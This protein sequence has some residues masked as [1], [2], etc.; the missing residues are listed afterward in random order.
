MS[1][2]LGD[3][4]A[5]DACL[6]H[7]R[8]LFAENRNDI[9]RR[10]DR[11]F[12]VLILCEW[13]A[14]MVVALIVS[15]RTWAGASSWVHIHVWAALGLGGAIASLPVVLALTRPGRIGTRHVIAAGQMLMGALLIHL[16]GGRIETHF[17][18]FGSLA[19]LAFYR[20]WRV[21]VTASVV[22][23]VD[24]LMRGSFWPRSV[25]GI[26]IFEP[27]RWVEHAGWVVFE[28][29]FL[30][31]FCLESTREMWRAAEREIEL[32]QKRA[33]EALRKARDELEMRV[34]DR[35]AE[36]AQINETLQAEITERKRAEEQLRS[37]DRARRALKSCNQ[38]L[39]RARDE[40]Q[41]L[42][43]LCRVIVH[44]AGYSL[45]W[46]GY[47]EQDEA[48]T[49]RPMAHAGCEEGYLRTVNVTWA[50]TERGHGPAGTAIRTRDAV[51]I[52][53]ATRDPRFAPWRAEALKR[54]YASIVGIPF[55]IGPDLVGAMTIY[56][57]TPD[58]FDEEEVKLLRELANDFSY[59]VVTLRMRTEHEKAEETLRESEQRYCHLFENLSDT[60]FL[61]DAETGRIVDTNKQGEVLLARPREE[62]IGMLQ[63]ELHRRGQVE[64]HRWRSAA[65]GE[66]GRAAD[67][68]SV[69]VRKDGTAIPVHIRTAPQTIGGKWFIL[70]LFR[71]IT[72]RKRA[73]ETLR[74]AYDEL[75]RRIEERTVA[76]AR[77]NEALSAEISDR[78]R[79]EEALRQT[80]ERFRTAFAEAAIGMVLATPD[81]RLLQ[82]N[83][84]YCAILGYTEQEL[85][86]R[87]YL[88][89]THPDDRENNLRLLG[90]LMAGEVST[91]VN[92]K[93]YLARSGAIVWVQSSVSLLRDGQDRP[94]HIIALVEDISVRKRAE[95]ELLRA[96]EAAEAASR[97][98]SEFLANMSHEIRTPM[99]GIIG[100]T[101]LVLDT[102]ARA[103][104]A[105]VPGDRRTR[106]PTPS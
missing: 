89:F 20:D 80:E 21:L 34:R 74:R 10:T 33:E 30:I 46:V 2:H 29:I 8:A 71:D 105:R 4:T 43:D 37:V 73:E 1:H 28:D 72:D 31:R 15:P 50:D 36:L 88:D 68:E 82:V 24:H 103:R 58:A 19:F 27:W 23:I 54:G 61:I 91:I 79:T 81:A 7:A 55:M 63:G 11:L 87:S 51:V 93:R 78:K 32:E 41:F 77:I 17:H 101:E 49:V 83:R 22:V 97:A 85:L 38:A 35:T 9:A 5:R 14:A 47:A 64:D 56:A 59:G 100:M 76:L 60:A 3:E 25:F 75:E 90:R 26:S 66:G 45:C 69:V 84:A 67:Y 62:I 16:T 98:K 94:L 44:D 39:I 96:K 104:A 40:S 42:Q 65:Q 86:S 53:D 13:L 95:E 18:V 102:A 99:N 48:R 52:K 12:A 106:R 92:E 70:G 57:S 6:G